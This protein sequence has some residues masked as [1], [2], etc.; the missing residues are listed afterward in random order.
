[1]PARAPAEKG[2]AISHSSDPAGGGILAVP[3]LKRP[4]P[5]SRTQAAALAA[6]AAGAG[7]RIAHSRHNQTD[8]EH[9]PDN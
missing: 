1:M 4:L 7:G 5:V 8:S 6:R 9:K 3:L 2:R